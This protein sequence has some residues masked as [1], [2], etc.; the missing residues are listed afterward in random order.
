MRHEGAI[1]VRN[2]GLV[3]ANIMG[4]EGVRLTRVCVV[5]ESCTSSLE[6]RHKITPTHGSGEQHKIEWIFLVSA[7]HS[8]LRS[9]WNFL[10]QGSIFK[11][12]ISETKGVGDFSSRWNCWTEPEGGSSRNSDQKRFLSLIDHPHYAPTGNSESSLKRPY[13]CA[14]VVPPPPFKWIYQCDRGSSVTFLV[15]RNSAVVEVR[16]VSLVFLIQSAA[17]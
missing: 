5:R 4:Y 16:P 10:G 14:R 1:L 12:S 15:W 11:F 8:T 6:F 7:L 13:Y 3:A 2:M 9:S 17:S